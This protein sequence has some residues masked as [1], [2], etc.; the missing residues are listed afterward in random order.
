[1]GLTQIGET[2]PALSA[3][4]Q[5]QPPSEPGF[6]SILSPDALSFVATLV[7]EFRQRLEDL[8]KQRQV[9]AEKIRTGKLPDFLTATT[10]VREGVWTIGNI[11]SDLKKRRVEITG[12]VDRKMI[13]NA[14]NSGADVYMADFEDSHSPT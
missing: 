4:I 14:L 2:N 9:T 12:P 11:P 8:L 7:I 3:N 10:N 5:I 6:E 13:I 1:M